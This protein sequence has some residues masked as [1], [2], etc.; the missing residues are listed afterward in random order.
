MLREE[1]E[2][3]IKKILDTYLKEKYIDFQIYNQSVINIRN[4]TLK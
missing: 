3:F 2:N 4:K 1:V